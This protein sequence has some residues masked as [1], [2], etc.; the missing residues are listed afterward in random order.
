MAFQPHPDQDITID[1]VQFSVAEHPHAPGM[2]YGQEGRQATVYQ[3][4]AIQERRAL[5]VFKPR[6]RVPSLVTLSGQLAPFTEL[7]GLRVCW[8]TILTPRKQIELLREY[9]DLTYAVLMPWIEGPTWME[10][11]LGGNALTPERSLAFAHAL[12]DTLAQM[13]ESGLAHCDLSA[14]NI[15]LCG[16]AEKGSEL[17]VLL[18]LVDV[19][20]M[21]GPDLRRPETLPA[22]SLGYAHREAKTGIWS[23]SADRF[24]GTLLI[25]E[26]LAWCDL[27]VREA[28]WGESYFD[29]GEIQKNCERYQLLSVSLRESWGESVAQLLERA[30]TS[31]T[32]SECPTF[33]DWLV[34]LPPSV[35]GPHAPQT[36]PAAPTLPTLA[37]YS[38]RPTELI[39]ATSGAATIASSA[40]RVDTTTEETVQPVL[41]ILQEELILAILF[42]DGFDAYQAGDWAQARELLGEVV[43]Q[44]PAY[45]RQGQSAAKLLARIEKLLATPAYPKR[46]LSWLV[47][48]TLMLSFLLLFGAIAIYQIQLGEAAKSQAT[49]T[50]QVIQLAATAQAEQTA[51]AQAMQSATSQARST[52]TTQFQQTST[53]VAQAEATAETL[54]VESTR[55]AQ[56]TATSQAQATAETQALMTTQTAQTLETAQAIQISQSATAEAQ[57][58]ATAAAIQASATE[59]AQRTATTRGIQAQVPTV[60][61][62]PKPTRVLPSPTPQSIKIA[63]EISAPQLL[64]PANGAVLDSPDQVVL[65]VAPIEWTGSGFV[66]YVWYIY[67]GYDTYV[68]GGNEEGTAISLADY[69]ADNIFTSVKLKRGD[70]IVWWAAARISK[71]E[72]PNIGTSEDRLGPYSQKRTFAVKP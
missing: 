23:A 40:R 11:L 48:P 43:R 45:T 9:P 58:N 53:V 37:P 54:Q 32:I 66:W 44:Q 70:P 22:G 57:A 33:G 13:E 24:A 29:P 31:D 39:A 26:M 56:V 59:A 18:E 6:F 62:P 67:D 17:P 41:P 8:R 61:L 72:N 49:A 7:P 69:Y 3:L 15:I 36:T 52:A 21:Y 60:T 50:A 46:R 4:K 42:K 55:N 35:R 38:D 34:A 63:D 12:A 71:Y 65:Q 47:L 28:G 25:A 14:S 2:P 27:H 5:K 1:G 68:L 19:E 51:T 20:Q 10:V 64:S 30:W 16:M